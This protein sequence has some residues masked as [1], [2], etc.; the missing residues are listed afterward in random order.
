MNY[1][2]YPVFLGSRELDISGILY[3]YPIGTK[4]EMYVGAFVL[5][6]EKGE[7]IL[8]DSGSPSIRE[9]KENGYG[10]SQVRESI[11][12]IDEIKKM[13]VEPEKVKTII[14]THL[15]WDH[16]WNLAHF[17]NAELIV[18]KIE[19]E[20]AI[21]PFKNSLKSYGMLK[22]CMGHNW[23]GAALQMKVVEGDVEVR[24][25]LK[26]LLTPGHTPGSQ[27]VAADTKDGTYLMIGDFAMNMRNITEAIPVASHN[28]VSDWYASYE[29]I[30]ATGYSLLPT[31][32][33]ITYS[34]KVYG[35][36]EA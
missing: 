7:Y 14:L 24:P 13:G 12:Y 3:R 6:D 1:K 15:H 30:Q 34:R 36:P 19:I 29:K 23:L 17:P 2:I 26:V 33:P 20:H 16:A 9:I 11:E 5:E 4:M 28:S 18:Q 32:D 22:P 10:F 31:H 27:S 21:H 35:G 8:V 25:G